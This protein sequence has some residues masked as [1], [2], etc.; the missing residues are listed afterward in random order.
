MQRHIGKRNKLTS[1]TPET[2]MNLQHKQQG[3][4]SPKMMRLATGL[5]G[6]CLAGYIAVPPIYW[7][8]S[9]TLTSVGHFSCPPCD[10]DCP[11]L[12]LF[13]NSQGRQK[14][15]ACYQLS[16]NDDGCLY[17]KYVKI[18]QLFRHWTV[19]FFNLRV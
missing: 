11:D 6:M 12:P 4:C 5:M 8:L 13:S 2:Q 1:I 16:L 19:N 17:Y 9:E 14:C 15:T 3:T 7:H 18:Q 10:C